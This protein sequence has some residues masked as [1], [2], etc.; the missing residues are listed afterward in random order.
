MHKHNALCFFSFL[1]ASL[2]MLGCF[3]LIPLVSLFIFMPPRLAEV[4]Q[5]KKLKSLQSPSK[6]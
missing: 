4:P 5:L 1:V 3:W 2:L 6:T